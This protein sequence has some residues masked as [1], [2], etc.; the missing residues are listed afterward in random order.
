M[1]MSIPI[2][3]PMLA[4]SSWAISNLIIIRTISKQ[5]DVCLNNDRMNDNVGIIIGIVRVSHKGKLNYT[6]D[7]FVKLMGPR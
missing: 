2:R 1:D 6:N 3:Y 4:Q 5:V 7:L